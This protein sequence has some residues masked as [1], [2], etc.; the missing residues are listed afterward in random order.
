MNNEIKR[1]P[2]LTVAN[3]RNAENHPEF[4]DSETLLERFEP[5]LKSIHHRF[6]TYQGVFTIYEDSSDLYNQIVY[7]FLRLRHSFDPKRGVDFTGYIKFHLQQRVYHYVMKRQ[8]VTQNEL[9][10]K[11]MNNDFE[12]KPMDLENIP[13][14]V[15]EDS[16][17]EFERIEAIA[18]IPWKSLS[19]SQAYMIRAILLNH[20]SIEDVAKETKCTLKS[21]KQDFEE[22]C[23]FLIELQNSKES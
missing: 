17:K 20:K 3:R 4:L 22:L 18:S 13:E 7:E 15:D 8:K 11:V 5:L 21:V 2:I 1:K 14:L 6:M 9:P 23:E 10:L 12:E 16:E 19:E